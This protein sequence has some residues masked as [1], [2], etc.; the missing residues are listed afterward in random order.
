M[1][2][3]EVL[4]CVKKNQLTSISLQST[5]MILYVTVAI[6]HYITEITKQH[7]LEQNNA[8]IQ[9]GEDQMT[10]I[11]L[12]HRNFCVMTNIVGGA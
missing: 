3:K 2:E 12:Y 9:H 1:C 6:I 7:I 10:C 4:E 11:S 8:S 5:Q